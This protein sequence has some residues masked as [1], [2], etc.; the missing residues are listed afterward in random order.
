MKFY[1]YSSTGLI[2]ILILLKKKFLN[3]DISIDDYKISLKKYQ[4]EKF[5]VYIKTIN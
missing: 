4:K 5:K 1:I 2:N 3:F